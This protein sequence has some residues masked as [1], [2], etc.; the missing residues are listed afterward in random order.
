VDYDT[1]VGERECYRDVSLV[2]GAA[3]EGEETAFEVGGIAV[4]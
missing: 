1:E 3:Y 4:Y 2:G